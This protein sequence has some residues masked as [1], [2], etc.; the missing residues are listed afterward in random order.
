MK[1]PEFI[2]ALSA[3]AAAL[4]AGP[5]PAIAKPQLAIWEFGGGPWVVAYDVEGARRAYHADFDKRF[6]GDNADEH[7][8]ID[9][10][11][12]RRMADNETFSMF[13]EEP[14]D[15]RG[16]LNRDT[17]NPC[18]CGDNHRNYSNDDDNDACVTVTLSCAE[19][20]VHLG[21]GHVIGEFQG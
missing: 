1:R 9:R 14:S 6:G 13:Y 18:A 11:Q 17:D 19:W 4:V 20:T 2:A 10:K 16:L 5:L 7:A 21:E 15:I 8:M 3:T 12:P